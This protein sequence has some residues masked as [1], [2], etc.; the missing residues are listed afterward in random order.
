MNFEIPDNRYNCEINTV[1][2]K[3]GVAKIKCFPGK[4][5]VGEKDDARVFVTSNEKISL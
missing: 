1:M 5:V 3:D 2:N 4:G